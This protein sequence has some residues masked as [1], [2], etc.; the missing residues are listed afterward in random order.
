M[1]LTPDPRLRQ[2]AT[3]QVLQR[4]VA[5]GRQ[6]RLRRQRRLLTVLAAAAVGGVATAVVLAPSGAVTLREVGPAS[7][8]PGESVPTSSA[9]A[10]ASPAPDLEPAFDRD[11]GR[12]CSQAPVVSARAAAKDWV[13]AVDALYSA[14]YERD[15]DR[16]GTVA[17]V[18][19]T[20][21]SLDVADTQT[22]GE[23][24]DLF[25]RRCS[26]AGYAE[27]LRECGAL[28]SVVREAVAPQVVA[29][30]ADQ[31][32]SSPI[33]VAVAGPLTVA[34]AIAADTADSHQRAAFF[35]L[36]DRLVGSDR[37]PGTHFDVNICSATPERVVTGYPTGVT[38]LGGPDPSCARG[39]QYIR[40]RW[41]VAGPKV[42]AADAIPEHC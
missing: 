11:L 21:G 24:T 23:V 37:S 1:P 27:P 25:T 33:E 20:F 35:F 39:Q 19:P 36:N 30:L 38:A 32:F 40:V 8:A 34:V 6:L 15:A 26:E 28:Y 2:T 12:L 3:D 14:W 13:A 17:E 41:S 31:G 18:L 10:S 7:P 9:P 42:Q 29:T 16:T 4:V 5:R 22:I